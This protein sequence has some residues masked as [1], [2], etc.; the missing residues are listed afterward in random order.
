M[1]L[2]CMRILWL[3]HVAFEAQFC[4]PCWLCVCPIAETPLCYRDALVFEPEN[5]AAIDNLSELLPCYN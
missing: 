2:L 5:E 3:P 1:L 4:V